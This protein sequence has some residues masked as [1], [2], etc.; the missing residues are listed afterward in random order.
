MAT[1]K[2]TS[3]VIHKA[4]SDIK[5]SAV[6]QESGVLTNIDDKAVSALSSVF[7][8]ELDVDDN[9]YIPVGTKTLL[10]EDFS[11]LYV[12]SK[13]VG[14]ALD[15]GENQFFIEPSDEYD[16]EMHSDMCSLSVSQGYDALSLKERAMYEVVLLSKKASYE[17]LNGGNSD[18]ISSEYAD[19]MNAYRSYCESNGVDWNNVIVGCSVELQ[20]EARDYLKSKDS[21]LPGESYSRADMNRVVTNCAHNVVILSGG[22][23]FKDELVPALSQDITYEDTMNVS[24]DYSGSTLSKV[25]N[26]STDFLGRILHAIKD[27]LSIKDNETNKNPSVFASI[28]QSLS[29]TMESIVRFYDNKVAHVNENVADY[30]S[31]DDYV[32]NSMSDESGFVESDVEEQFEVLS[33]QQSDLQAEQQ[34]FESNPY[35]EAVGVER[36]TVDGLKETV[37]DIKD[38]VVEGLDYGIDKIKKNGVKSTFNEL[39]D[40]VVDKAT[41]MYD[42][43]RNT[44]LVEN[45]NSFVSD[46]FELE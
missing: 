2:E 44:D 45:E 3:D 19:K 22:A 4:F 24:L 29:E 20:T 41:D 27:K 21:V 43:Y 11:S 15:T 6:L 17:I 13:P 33:E 35:Y 8:R 12:S 16:T 26:T 25:A 46:D 14:K 1:W 40:A 32:Q 18:K 37:N 9:I 31:E 10:G 5:D 39:K 34:Q 36:D 7:H 38:G 30:L 23:S 42:N 28:K